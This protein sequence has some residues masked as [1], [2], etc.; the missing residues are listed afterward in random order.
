MSASQVHTNCL[1]RLVHL[2]KH[3]LQY[4]H[5]AASTKPRAHMFQCM[6]MIKLPIPTRSPQLLTPYMLQ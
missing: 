5:I 2:V 3:I 6:Y 4:R 1:A